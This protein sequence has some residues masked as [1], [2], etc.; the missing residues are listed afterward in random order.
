MSIS[1][2]IVL[3]TSEAA[4][5]DDAHTA[6]TSFI[7]SSHDAYVL[8]FTFLL[9]YLTKSPSFAAYKKA[10]PAYTSSLPSSQSF[11]HYLINCYLY[12]LLA[13]HTFL[14]R[15]TSHRFLEL[16]SCSTKESRA[17][18]LYQLDTRDSTMPSQTKKKNATGPPT[19]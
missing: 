3:L 5:P 8:L 12:S 14:V 19:R 15:T 16:N 13:P 4:T 10:G 1:I 6:E 11:L 9:L 17:V 18:F 7:R 2:V